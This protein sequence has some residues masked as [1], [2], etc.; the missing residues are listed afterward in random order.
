MVEVRWLDSEHRAIL[1]VFHANATVESLKI[2]ADQTDAMTSHR[3]CFDV[4]ADVSQISMLP[5]SIVNVL[6]QQHLRAPANYGV[7]VIV[8]ANVFVRAILGVASQLASIRGRYVL[9]ET[10]DEA[11]R[12]L[13][14]RHQVEC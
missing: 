10:L 11:V 3:P 8:G 5:A 14:S 6:R 4:V 7:T 9:A 13:R 1:W 12:F 2:A